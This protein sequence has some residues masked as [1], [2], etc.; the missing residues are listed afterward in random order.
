MFSIIM[1]AWQMMAGQFG[2]WHVYYQKN[3]LDSTSFYGFFKLKY[4]FQSPT[5]KRIPPFSR[6]RSF[7]CLLVMVCTFRPLGEHVEQW[8]EP[9]PPGLLGR[10]VTVL[11]Y[12][13]CVRVTT[14]PPYHS[15]VG[16]GKTDSPSSTSVVTTLQP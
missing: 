16:C 9:L 13:T 2:R 1:L 7:I 10:W 5:P 4:N 11:G 12:M 3:L 6:K 15:V 8:L 14:W